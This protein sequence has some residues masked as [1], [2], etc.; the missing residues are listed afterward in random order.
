MG[1]KRSAARMLRG[2]H[3]VQGQQHSAARQVGQVAVCTDLDK[4][5]ISFGNSV[6][7]SHKDPDS[8]VSSF[9]HVSSHIR[10]YCE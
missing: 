7:L 8:T 5:L 9:K 1:L 3:T 4:Y 6:I 10:D 2:T